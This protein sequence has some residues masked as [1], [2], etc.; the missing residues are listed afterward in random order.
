M[1]LFC[2][3]DDKEYARTAE[4]HPNFPHLN[5]TWILFRCSKCKRF[6]KISMNG[7]E[8]CYPNPNSE[9]KKD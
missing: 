7:E 8:S 9:I 6:K 5:K 3:H 2:K 1:S 4:I